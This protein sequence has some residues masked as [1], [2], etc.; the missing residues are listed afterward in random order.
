MNRFTDFT[1]YVHRVYTR[2]DG[3]VYPMPINLGTI[4]QFLTLH[5][6]R[7]KRKHLLLNKPGSWPVLI[8]RTSTIRAFR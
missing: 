3:V 4:N 7:L 5:I 2:H 8:R 6:H 1:N